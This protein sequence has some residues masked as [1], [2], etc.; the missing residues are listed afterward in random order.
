MKKIVLSAIAIAFTLCSCTSHDEG[1]VNEY[2]NA[3]IKENAQKVFGNID[4][5]Q[6]WNE[7]YQ[8]G[9]CHHYG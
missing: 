3:L 4:A 1:N 5:A 8:T 6:D 2:N 9:F 7:L